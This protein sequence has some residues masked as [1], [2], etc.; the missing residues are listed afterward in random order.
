MQM[1]VED[2]NALPN[3]VQR[4]L[5]DLTVEMKCGV[6]VVEQFQ[7]CFRGDG[8][9]SQQQRHHQPRGGRADR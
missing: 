7:S 2:G 1:G 4:G 5:Q 9:L 8:A 6:G 3:V